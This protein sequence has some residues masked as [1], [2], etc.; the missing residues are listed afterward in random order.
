[1]L[2]SAR[3]NRTL[4]EV[5][6]RV[7]RRYTSRPRFPPLTMPLDEHD[8]DHEGEH[9]PDECELCLEQQGTVT[10]QCRCGKCCEHLL[11]DDTLRDVEREP[12][13]AEVGRPIYDDNLGQGPRNWSA[14]I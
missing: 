14:I 8:L 6:D 7:V 12:R 5:D 9:D 11:F 13:I 10:N 3:E 4:P 2:F 1:M